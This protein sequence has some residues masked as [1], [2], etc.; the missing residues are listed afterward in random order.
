[1]QEMEA[2]VERAPSCVYT[3]VLRTRQCQKVLWVMG[4]SGPLLKL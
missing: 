3:A 2:S 4:V 1:M